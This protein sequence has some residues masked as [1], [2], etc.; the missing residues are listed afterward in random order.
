[1]VSCAISP[2]FSRAR[3]ASRKTTFS[4][5]SACSRIMWRTRPRPTIV[6][7]RR[8]HLIALSHTNTDHPRGSD[9]VMRLAFST[10]AY[11]RYPFDE[12]AQ[13]ITAIGYAGLELMAD[14]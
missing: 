10:N 2:A 3:R 7:V 12:A 11:L 4:N 6:D 8:N 13:R 5:S 9:S 14:V 1:M